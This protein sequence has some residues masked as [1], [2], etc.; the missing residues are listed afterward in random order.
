MRRI[1]IG[2]K[3]EAR[4]VA[5]YLSGAEYSLIRERFGLTRH[6]IYNILLRRG[7][8]TLRDRH[9]AARPASQ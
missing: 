6:Q 2:E 1:D 7:V 3:Q 8:A 4:L 5:L 9:E